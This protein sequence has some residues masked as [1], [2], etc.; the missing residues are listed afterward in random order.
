MPSSLTLHSSF[1]LI[2]AGFRM[3]QR[4]I[5][6]NFVLIFRQ[7]AK[8]DKKYDETLTSYFEDF[9]AMCRKVVGKKAN[10]DPEQTPSK[11][12]FFFHDEYIMFDIPHSVLIYRHLF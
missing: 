10:K 4:C 2:S 12:L 5:F 7:L 11:F 3:F 9:M 6:S 1:S 8:L